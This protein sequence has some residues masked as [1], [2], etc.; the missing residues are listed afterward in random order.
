MTLGSLISAPGFVL[1]PVAIDDS[2]AFE[3]QKFH[4]LEDGHGVVIRGWSHA[5]VGPWDPRCH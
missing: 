5:S 1:L 4:Q 2:D 3:G